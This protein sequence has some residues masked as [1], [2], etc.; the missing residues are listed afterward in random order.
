MVELEPGEPLLLYI[1]TTSEAMRMV[2]VTERPDPHITRELE[3][4]S[5]GGSGS[6]D[7][8]PVKEPRVVATAGSQS[9]KAA[10]GLH[11][12]AVVGPQTSEVSSDA[13]DRELPG[14]ALMEIDTPDPPPEGPDCPASGILH[15]RGPA[16]GQDHVSGGP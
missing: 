7:S 11:D 13:E 6:Q 14:P 1:A 10:A 9:P 15:Q 8:G 3:S 2:L 5:A 16:R 12:Q 4:S